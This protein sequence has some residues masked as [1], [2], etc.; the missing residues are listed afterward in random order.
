MHTIH[1]NERIRFELLSI[2]LG[3]WDY[4]KNSGNHPESANWALDWIGMMT[5]K[6]ESR[7]LVGDHLLTQFD[8]MGINGDFEDAV[9]IGGWPMDDHPPGGFDRADLPP[10]VQ[11]KTP[12]Y[13]MPLRSSIDYRLYRYNGEQISALFSPE[14]YPGGFAWIAQ[15]EATAMGQTLKDPENTGTTVNQYGYA[16]DLNVRVKYNRMRLRF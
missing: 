3:V 14:K 1:D 15:L 13:N 2:V 8:L 11:V 6:R 10:C 4:I 5:G 7:R 9:C 16:G 12:I